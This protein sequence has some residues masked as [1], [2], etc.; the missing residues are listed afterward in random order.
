MG[1]CNCVQL[2]L[3]WRFVC[4]KDLKLLSLFPK[5]NLETKLLLFNNM[6]DI[7]IDFLVRVTF[8]T[9]KMTK[10]LR[11]L[12]CNLKTPSRE[13]TNLIFG[14]QLAFNLT[15]LMRTNS[16]YIIRS[17]NPYFKVFFIAIWVWLQH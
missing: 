14:M 13:P 7:F 2:G 3:D 8:S 1:V 10:L 11:H 17:S 15:N 9:P 16:K 4:P 12:Y 5:K 6:I